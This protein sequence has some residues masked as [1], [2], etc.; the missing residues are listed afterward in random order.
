MRDLFSIIVMTIGLCIF[1]Y[2]AYV[3]GC[4]KRGNEQGINNPYE[5]MERMK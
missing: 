1:L 4:D 2:M 3:V 5:T